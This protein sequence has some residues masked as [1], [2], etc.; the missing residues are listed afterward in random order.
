MVPSERGSGYEFE[1][2]IFGGSIP[3]NFIPAV[4]K[5]IKV[6]MDRGV[7]AGYQGSAFPNGQPGRPAGHHPAPDQGKFSVELRQRMKRLYDVALIP[8]RPVIA[9]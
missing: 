6:R 8:I 4:E 7:L 3:N 1:D 2:K 9:G 5:G